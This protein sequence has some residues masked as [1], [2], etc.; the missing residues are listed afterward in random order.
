[1][2]GD[3]DMDQVEIETPMPDAFRG[4]CD[5]LSFWKAVGGIEA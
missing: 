4:S 1:M 3:T 2:A 5:L